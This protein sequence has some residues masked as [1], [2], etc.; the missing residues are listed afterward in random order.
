MTVLEPAARAFADATAGPPYPYDVPVADGRHHLDSLQSGAPVVSA[1][2]EDLV[3]ASGVRIRIYRPPGVRGLLPVVV[4]THGGGWVVGGT[5]THDRLVRELTVRSGA[6]LVFVSYSLSPEAVYPAALEEV[7][8]TLT[9]IAAEG[10]AHDLDFSRMAVAGDSAG[11]AI[12]A[13]VT[14][15]LKQ[16]GGPRLAAQLLYYPVTD[17]SFDT[18][19]YRA[20]ATGY[21]LRRDAMEWFWD[22][23]APDASRRAEMTA[24]PLRAT[25]DDLAGLP[26]A[27]VVTAEADVLRD[28]G[29]AYAAA[30]R[31]AGVDV[32]AVRYLGITHDFVMLNA[33]KDTAAARAATAQGAAFLA[34][35]LSR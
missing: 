26:P 10:F 27:L 5:R 2:I 7:Y 33:L 11:G 21:W 24:S 28:E 25:V 22:Q 14:L 19:S 35:H 20:F 31:T 17:A 32:T 12:T 9:W 4:Y 16:R 3:I 34:G 15:L 8:T 1:S 23:Y 30:L 18:G 29:E 6:A 13:A